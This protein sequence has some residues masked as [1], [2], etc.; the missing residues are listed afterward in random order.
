MVILAY[1]FS[2]TTRKSR[3]IFTN[4]L[5]HLSLACST[6]NS[7]TTKKCDLYEIRCLF[8][9]KLNFKSTQKCINTQIK[10]T[11]YEKENEFLK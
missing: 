3:R 7:T 5:S 1:S 11:L 10:L 8:K 4:Y 2:T 9:K 6:N